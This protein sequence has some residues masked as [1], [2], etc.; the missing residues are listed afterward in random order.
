[1]LELGGGIFLDN[2]EEIE[3]GKLI[4]VKKIVGNYTKNISEKLNGFKKIMVSLEGE[5]TYKI[6]IEIEASEKFVA[7]GEKENLFFALDE[8][9][10]GI[11]NQITQ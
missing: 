7:Q 1:M 8:A 3:P 4:I 5:N 2:F 10:S 9:L 11:N 6:K